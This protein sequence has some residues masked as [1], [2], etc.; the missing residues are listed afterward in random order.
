MKYEPNQQ[1]RYVT[2]LG[3]T[4]DGKAWKVRL[5]CCGTVTTRT[6][7]QLTRVRTASTNMCSA[8]CITALKMRTWKPQQAV[9]GG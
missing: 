4:Q 5:G 8:C 2:V 6:D 3:P 7:A 1:V 9:G